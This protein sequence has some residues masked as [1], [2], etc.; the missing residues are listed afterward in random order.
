MLT[1]NFRIGTDL[2]FSFWRRR[3]LQVYHSTPTKQIGWLEVFLHVVN[4]EVA[5]LTSLERNFL[6]W[7][8]PIL[9]HHEKHPWTVMN[10]GLGQQIH[11]ESSDFAFSLEYARLCFTELAHCLSESLT[12]KKNT[13]IQDQLFDSERS[14]NFAACKK[15]RG[16]LRKH[17]LL[18][19][20]TWYSRHSLLL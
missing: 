2:S 15:T 19:L 11:I 4:L 18:T 1:V 3:I 20:K 12:L 14:T 6:C 5:H 16:T 10:H 17:A 8:P 13:K 9:K 7:N